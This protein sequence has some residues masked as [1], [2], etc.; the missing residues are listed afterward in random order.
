[1][2]SIIEHLVDFRRLLRITALRTAKL[3]NQSDMARDAGLSQPTAHRYL[4]L[5]EASHLLH[6]LPAY[7]VI[8]LDH[9][10][11]GIERAVPQARAFI[12]PGLDEPAG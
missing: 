9:L 6:R 2:L 12:R 11:R 8:R 5:L 1:M 4:G 3:M 10:R 7:A